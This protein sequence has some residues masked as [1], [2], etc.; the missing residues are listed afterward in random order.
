[1]I[2]HLKV[3]YDENSI[4]QTKNKTIRSLARK[5]YDHIKIHTETVRE[6]STL[7]PQWKVTPIFI[8]NKL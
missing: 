3:C 4:L 7:H 5:L 8:W 2:F 6:K 1:M